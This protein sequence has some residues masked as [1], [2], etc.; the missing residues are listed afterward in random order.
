MFNNRQYDVASLRDGLRQRFDQV[1][2]AREDASAC[3]A[4]PERTGETECLG[5]VIYLPFTLPSFAPVHR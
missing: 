1:E 3:F 4:P 2:I 5:M